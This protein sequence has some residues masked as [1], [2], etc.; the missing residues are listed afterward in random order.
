HGMS[1]L[2]F[3]EAQGAFIGRRGPSLQ[4][5][6]F[7]APASAAAKEEFDGR[8]TRE[9]PFLLPSPR[10]GE[11]RR[12]PSPLT[13]LP[14]GERGARGPVSASWAACGSRPFRPR[15]PLCRCS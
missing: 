6:L 1:S 8:S 15:R 4:R 10:W 7:L 9:G 3:V 5:R 13:P 12:S 14:S 11:G 2:H